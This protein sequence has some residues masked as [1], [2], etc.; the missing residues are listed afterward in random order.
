[1][2]KQTGRTLY[3][4]IPQKLT[5]VIHRF[6]EGNGP[7]KYSQVNEDITNGLMNIFW[8]SPPVQQPRGQT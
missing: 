7:E 3:L 1:M 5:F 4:I 6:E 2:Q 8:G